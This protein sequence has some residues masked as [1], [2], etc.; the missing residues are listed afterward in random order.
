ML[1]FTLIFLISSFCLNLI[2][3]TAIMWIRTSSIY[4]VN[5]DRTGRVRL[6]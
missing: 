4:E 5:I 6:A 2:V 3:F 1:N